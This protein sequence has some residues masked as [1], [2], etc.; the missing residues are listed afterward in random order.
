M[1]FNRLFD[2]LF[3][4]MFYLV[5]DLMFG[6]RIILLFTLLEKRLFYRF[7]FRPVFEIKQ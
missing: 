2:R 5:F 6:N 7:C 1:R 4:L 3:D